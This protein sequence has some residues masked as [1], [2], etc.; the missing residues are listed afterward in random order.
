[1]IFKPVTLRA[2]E[3]ESGMIGSLAFRW[4]WACSSRWSD[5]L[6]R[7][8]VTRIILDRWSGRSHHHKYWS[9]ES[10]SIVLAIGLR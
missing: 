10:K 2:S 4:G 5:C 3:P 8:S 9:T 6:A 7:S 1:M